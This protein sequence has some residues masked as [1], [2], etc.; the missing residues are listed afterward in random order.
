MKK[1]KFDIVLLQ[2]EEL[3]TSL[4]STW[5]W[6]T[7]M[8]L[9]ECAF[10]RRAVVGKYLH[11]CARQYLIKT[12]HAS[13]ACLSACCQL[14]RGICTFLR[15]SGRACSEPRLFRR[16]VWRHE[17]IPVQPVACKTPVTA[18]R[19]CA[20]TWP[21][22]INAHP[23]LFQRIKKT[24]RK[25]HGETSDK[26][27]SHRCT[28]QQQRQPHASAARHCV[29]LIKHAPACFSLKTSTSAQY[30]QVDD[31]SASSS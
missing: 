17:S 21:A 31:V 22:R 12:D 18:P 2:R 26:S 15:H 3:T 29:S 27:T 23:T 30:R 20:I 25:L 5:I 7:L 24:G 14:S 19:V 8:C 1:T 13:R 6:V 4:Y 11:F 28:Q 10:L 9:S 16:I